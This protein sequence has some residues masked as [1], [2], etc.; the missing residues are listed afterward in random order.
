[1]AI[2]KEDEVNVIARR[3]EFDAGHRVLG[4]EG[5]CA[6]LHGHRYV[7]EVSVTP[8]KD[9]D[10]LGRVI[11]YGVIKA[12]VGQWIDEFWDHNILLHPEDPLLRIVKEV[13][14]LGY[15]SKSTMPEFF[16]SITDWNIVF[17]PKTPYIMTEY[18]NPTAENISRELYDVSTRLLAAHP[19]QVVAVQIWETPNCYA[20]YGR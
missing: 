2:H 6:N 11:D 5:K 10:K 17:G 7:A 12:V 20:R 19:V 1:M 18:G 15:E 14:D 4:H 16:K 3:M 13:N 9:L 8:N